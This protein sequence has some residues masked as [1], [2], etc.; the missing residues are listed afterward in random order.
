MAVSASPSV[1]AAG[2]RVLYVAGSAG[3]PRPDR[4]VVELLRSAGFVVTPI[5]DDGVDPTS[6]DGYDVVVISSSVVPGKVGSTFT[7]SDVGVVSTEAYLLD[8]LGMTGASSSG[9]GERTGTTVAMVDSDHQIAAGRTGDVVVVSGGSLTFGQPAATASVIA[10]VAGS[11]DAALFAYESGASMVGIDAPARRVGL[12]MTY[13]NA[14]DLTSDGE[15]LVVGAVQ[16]A[17]STEPADTRRRPRRRPTTTTT[18]TTEPGT[19]TTTVEPPD[20]GGDHDDGSAVG[21]SVGVGGADGGDAG[22]DGDAW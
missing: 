14:D 8:D 5:D 9:R 7:G 18:T 12:F 6:A 4:A 2:E 21:W 16:W 11:S 19:T 22:G 10:T 20:N 15:D 1:E 3:L 13:D 17:A